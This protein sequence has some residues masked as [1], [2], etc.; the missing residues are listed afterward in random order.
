MWKE[1]LK[2]LESFP[3]YCPKSAQYLALKPLDLEYKN[4][5][6]PLL[7]SLSSKNWRLVLT[8]TLWR[9][10]LVDLTLESTMDSIL[11]QSCLK[12]WAETFA[13]HFWFNTISECLKSLTQS[14]LWQLWRQWEKLL[15]LSQLN[16]HQTERLIFWVSVHSRS[17]RLW[18]LSYVKIKSCYV[19]VMVTQQ[20]AVR[21][22]QV[23]TT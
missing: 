19:Q 6:K 11:L 16:L 4:Q 21:V 2:K 18:L 15:K 20:V 12:A 10:H 17:S 1:L 3:C 8:S 22:S 9:A 7:V 5:K 14:R 13:A 23:K